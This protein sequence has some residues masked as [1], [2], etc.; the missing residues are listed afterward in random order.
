MFLNASATE[1][2]LMAI[3]IVEFEEAE[4]Q[5]AICLN[6]IEKQPVALDDDY[7]SFLESDCDDD[8]FGDDSD[9]GYDYDLVLKHDGNFDE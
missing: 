3:A 1:A 8:D 6:N 5:Q 4:L 9:D 7:D 2:E